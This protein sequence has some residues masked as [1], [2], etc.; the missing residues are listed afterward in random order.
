[1]EQ[2]EPRVALGV[3]LRGIASAAIDVS[4]GLLGDLAHVLHRSGVGATV[5]VDAVPR[6]PDLTA[7]ALAL[8]RLCSLSGGDDY[9]LIF[10]APPAAQSRLMDAAQGAG[11]A[12]ARIGRIEAEPG[13]R[14]VDAAGRE[15]ANGW[16]SFDHFRS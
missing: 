5:D 12:V 16:T 13:L 11:V 4:D 8:Q 6:S 1:M 7:Q 15:V 10:T 14:L 3:A 2:P 9:E